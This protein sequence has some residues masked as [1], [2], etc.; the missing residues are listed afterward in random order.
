MIALRKEADTGHGTAA[1]RVYLLGQFYTHEP[2][3]ALRYLRLAADRGQVLAMIDLGAMLLQSEN[4][5][6]RK[7]GVELLGSAALA[8]NHDARVFLEQH[9]IAW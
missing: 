8:G 9:G 6:D 3:V 4:A 7:R 5:A 2:D 1:Y